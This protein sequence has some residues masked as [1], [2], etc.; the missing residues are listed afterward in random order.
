MFA[1]GHF[2]LGYLFGKGSSKLLKTKLNM[3]LLLVVSVTPDVDLILQLVDPA[4]FMHR[5]PSH[6]I[7]TFTALAIPFLVIYRK[8]ALP[9]YAALLSHSLIGDFFTGGLEL[10]W[11]VSQDWFGLQTIDVRS[12][13]VAST[14]IFLFALALV[15]MF[16]TKDLQALLKPNKANSLLFIA[17]GAVLGPML[18]VGNAYESSLPLLLWVPSIFCLLLFVYSVFVELRH[19]PSR[20]LK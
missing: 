20:P 6:A 10:F 11:P 8:Q 13:P 12:L 3:P 18:D 2:A 9:Y 4:L 16:R 5:G 19:R 15:I 1:I 17:F 7:I 14:E